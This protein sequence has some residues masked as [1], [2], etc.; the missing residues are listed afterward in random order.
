MSALLESFKGTLAGQEA[1]DQ[2]ERELVAWGAYVAG[3]R[4]A[5]GY[6]SMSVMHPN[7]QPPAKGGA[8]KLPRRVV[9]YAREQWV[10]AQVRTMSRKL[11]D[12]LVARY[13]MRMS[14]HDQALALHCE[15]ST[16]QARVSA[17]KRK[18][19]AV[20]PVIGNR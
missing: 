16:V 3:G 20:F 11:Q 12:A 2:M 4:D 6:P 13:V 7:W 19:A 1:L 5:S 8:S 10:D 15:L 18:L 9:S 17:A 14:L